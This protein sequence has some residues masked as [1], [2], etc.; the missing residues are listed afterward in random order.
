M[1][2][3][4]SL[5]MSLIIFLASWTFFQ[6]P[7]F[8][9]KPYRIGVG[10][11][12]SIMVWNEPGLDQKLV[13]VLPDG[14]ISFPLVGRIH[15]AGYTTD[16]LSRVIANNLKSIFK[17]KPAV[18]VTVEAIGNNIFYIMGSVG[19]PGIIPFNHNISLLQAII[20]AGGVTPSGKEDSIL[21]LRKDRT[22]KISLEDIEQGKHIENNI[23]IRAGDI[24][25]VPTKTDQIFIMG[26]VV[27]P[28]P[29]FYDK[30]MTVMKAIIG[31]HGFTQYASSSVKI[32]RENKDK[33]K[34]II[35]V[36]IDDVENEKKTNPKEYL[37]PGDVIY[38]PERMF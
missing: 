34:K 36:D 26:A 20:M 1:K 13:V 38:V 31:A 15:A 8:A 12:L 14:T 21:V 2:V 33:T 30:G 37:K 29:Y 22:V 23:P 18:T 9:G 16:S 5:F 6:T 11:S 10:D 7:A 19:H 4:N 25:I 35:H 28:G 24:I 32:I 27:N 3:I 17:K